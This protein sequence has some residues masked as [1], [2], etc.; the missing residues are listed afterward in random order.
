MSMHSSLP[1]RIISAIESNNITLCETYLAQLYSQKP[2]S[3]IGIPIETINS[4]VLSLSK[5]NTQFLT[6]FVKY[7]SPIIKYQK[8]SY[9]F[10][11]EWFFSLIFSNKFNFFKFIYFFQKA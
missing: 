8:T 6:Q 2:V 3:L 9:I 4:L 11:S 5:F 1:S 10:S 7:Y